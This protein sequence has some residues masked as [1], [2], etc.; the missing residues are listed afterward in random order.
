MRRYNSPPTRRGWIIGV[1]VV[2][3][4]LVIIVGGLR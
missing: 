3:V 2:I 4:F 1:I